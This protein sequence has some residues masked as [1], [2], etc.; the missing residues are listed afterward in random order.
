MDES[1][2]QSPKFAKFLLLCHVG[3]LVLFLIGK[4][5]LDDDNGSYQ[6]FSK[7]GIYPPISIMRDFY[8]SKPLNQYNTLLIIFTSNLI[9][10]CF[11][12]GTHQQFYSWYSYSFP[13]LANAALEGPL[14]QFSMI[15]ILEIAWSVCK[16]RSPLQSYA[17]NAAH[18][19]LVVG[20]WR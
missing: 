5:T 3:L 19:V 20:L 18:C 10:M 17:L 15:L 2:F 14:S 8:I 13:F 12:R 4:W 9:G 11:S 6:L 16:P 1:D 7:V